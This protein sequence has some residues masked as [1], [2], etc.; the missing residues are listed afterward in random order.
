VKLLA[1]N[2]SVFDD[3]YEHGEHNS[4]THNQSGETRHSA[5]PQSEDALVFDNP[6]CADKTVFVVFAGLE[7]LHS[8]F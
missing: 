5:G 6:G 1:T 2:D 4:S 3:W 7:R 8:F